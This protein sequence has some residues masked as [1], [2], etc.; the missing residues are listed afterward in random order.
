MAHDSTHPS[1]HKPRRWLY[2]PHWHALVRVIQNILLA[3]QCE[4]DQTHLSNLA[5]YGDDSIVQTRATAPVRALSTLSGFFCS[6][7]WYTWKE[8]KN[9]WQRDRDNRDKGHFL[10][11]GISQ[12]PKEPIG[13][14]HLIAINSYVLG[15]VSDLEFLAMCSQAGRGGEEKTPYRCL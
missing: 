1:W 8:N 11:T 13:L 3:S 15:N 4:H 7:T 10:R 5:H 6:I 2:E 14:L 9:I 12:S